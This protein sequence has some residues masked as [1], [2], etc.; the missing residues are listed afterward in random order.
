M[1]A[2]SATSPGRFIAV[3]AAI[4][5]GRPAAGP[6]ADG[7]SIGPGA[8]AL[9]RMP[10]WAY[11]TAA[12]R[13]SPTIPCVDAEYAARCAWAIM[14]AVD[15]IFKIAPPPCSTKQ[16]S[17]AFTQWNVPVRLTLITFDQSCSSISWVSMSLG[18]I[19]ALFR[20][21]PSPL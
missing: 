10:R 8:M 12:D 19:P 5:R 13:V 9:I 18:V 2:T 3:F 17:S 16:A 7:P 1:A 21:M 20:A 11:S 14:P 4:R 6:L 15:A